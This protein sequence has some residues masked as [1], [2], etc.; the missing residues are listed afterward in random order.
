[1]IVYGRVFIRFAVK[2]VEKRDATFFVISGSRI[3]VQFLV[4]QRTVQSEVLKNKNT[5]RIHRLFM[6]K[7]RF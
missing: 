4:P 6:S 2:E 1:M 7:Y 3:E 5:C